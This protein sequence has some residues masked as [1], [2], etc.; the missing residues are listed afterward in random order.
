MNSS[1]FFYKNISMRIILTLLTLFLYFEQGYCI[2]EAKLLK[3]FDNITCTKLIPEVKKR[4]IEALPNSF[5]TMAV[6]MQSGTYDASFRINNYSA[7]SSPELWAK[8]LNHYVW[9]KADNPTG[10][11]VEAGEPF[12]VLVGNT[13]GNRLKILCCNPE[14]DAMGEEIVLNEGVNHLTTKNGGLL[15]IKYYVEDISKNKPIEIHIPEGSGKVNGYWDVQKHKTESEFSRLLSISD[16]PYFDIVGKYYHMIFSREFIPKGDAMGHLNRIDSMCKWNRELLGI[17]DTQ[18]NHR[19]VIVSSSSKKVYATNYRTHHP[20]TNVT[21]ILDGSLAE[22]NGLWGPAH[23]IGHQLQG[24]LNFHGC[25]ESS[26]NLFSN[27]F[28]WKSKI[29][30][31]RG[32][33]VSKV[34][35]L[36]QDSAVNFILREQKEGYVKLRMY[37]QLY[38]YYHIAEKNSQFYPIFFNLLL[39]EK[40]VNP[41]EEAMNFYIL[42]CDAAKEDLTDFFEF[43]GFFVPLSRTVNDYGSKE[44]ILTSSMI[45]I[46]KQ[47]VKSKNYPKAAPI[48]YIEDRVRENV[49]GYY[50][51]YKNNDRICSAISVKLKDKTFTITG[52]DMAVAF[53]LK[54]NDEIIFRS[55][56]YSF[57][58]PKLPVG[59]KLYAV[60][61]DGQRIAIDY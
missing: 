23:E 39:G 2:D 34:L 50:L 12:Y 53:E 44:H 32:V 1:P 26:N 3:V 43:W 6:K 22:K 36:F 48:E 35:E 51:R 38:T 41:Q 31:S 11:W 33:D 37:W 47:T 42:A 19:H 5:K 56:N 57:I 10:I 20:N 45:D 24:A 27:L 17:D 49:T 14:Q 16:A 28:Y 40:F 21:K 15:Y 8:R 61:S 46:A 54:L 55:A 25:T 4:D 58:V 60:Q 52:G 29:R 9:G 30:E 59:S 18:I 7:Y 13:W